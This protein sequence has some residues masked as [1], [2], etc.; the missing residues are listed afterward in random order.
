MKLIENIIEPKKVIVLWQAIDKNTN[1][2]GGA[3]FVVGEISNEGVASKLTYYDN[4][5]TA[6]AV[7]LGFKGLT[8]YPFA[9]N[10]VWN[11]TVA[12]VLATRLPPNTRADYA[13]FLRAYRISPQAAEKISALGLVANTTGNLVGDGFSFLPS[14]EG[15]QPPFEFAF[16]IA[17]FRHHGLK[18]Y[19]NLTDLQGVEVSFADDAENEYDSEA[20]WVDY[21]NQHLGHVP[22]GLNTALR[23]L[24]PAHKIVASIERLNGTQERPNILVFVE[25]K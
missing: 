15:L 14:F 1:K 13:D 6:K 23:A 24:L 20:M 12:D 9:P 8:T 18:A 19:P 5:D 2:A 17:G 10:K 4:A 22:K 25:V 16:D 7:E 11:G 3:R 21:Q